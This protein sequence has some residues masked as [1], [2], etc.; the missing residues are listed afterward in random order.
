[1]S[2]SCH[3]AA[4]LS[5]ETLLP[6]PRGFPMPLCSAHAT[7]MRSLNSVYP[8]FFSSHKSSQSKVPS[9]GRP[10]GTTTSYLPSAGSCATAT[11]V[12][13]LAASW[14]IRH[15]KGNGASGV[16][17]KLV[18][19]L[20]PLKLMCGN[21]A[22]PLRLSGICCGCEMRNPFL[23]KLTV[24]KFELALSKLSKA[25]TMSPRAKATPALRRVWLWTKLPS[26][27][28]HTPSL[29]APT[30]KAEPAAE[31][32]TLRTCAPFP[33]ASEPAQHS[34][35]LAS[36][37]YLPLVK[38]TEALAPANKLLIPPSPMAMKMPPHAEGRRF[39]VVSRVKKRTLPWTLGF[40]HAGASVSASGGGP[41]AFAGSAGFAGSA[42]FASSVGAGSTSPAVLAFF[43]AG[44]AMVEA[45]TAA[46]RGAVGRRRP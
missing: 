30:T 43:A 23:N 18:C 32:P 22:L 2:K 41:T 13:A 34:R 25:A 37:M 29:S 19:T 5:P 20:T 46:C 26:D 39:S 11:A 6:A 14:T 28:K 17:P 12:S 16:G 10:T 7:S 38:P 24:L 15:V 45:G 36:N 4:G 31:K 3:S 42:T 1:M 27:S 33:R 40:V 35:I 9:S 21:S 8:A 44:C